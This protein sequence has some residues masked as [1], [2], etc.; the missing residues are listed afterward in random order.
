MSTLSLS[1]GVEPLIAWRRVSFFGLCS[2]LTVA[3]LLGGCASLPAPVAVP[4]THAIQD[5]A[6]TRLAR[7]AAQNALPDAG[8]LSGFRLLPEAPFSFNARIALA[9]RGEMS[10]MRGR[11]EERFKGSVNTRHYGDSPV[12]S[13]HHVTV[14]CS[15]STRQS[16]GRGIQVL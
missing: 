13:V 15:G 10:I 9:N 5:V 2:L 16:Q 12:T 11:I 7:I 1:A 6:S 14:L 3:P 4:P 8:E